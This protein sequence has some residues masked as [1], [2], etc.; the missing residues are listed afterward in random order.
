MNNV[1]CGL[2]QHSKKEMYALKNCLDKFDF[3]NLISEEFETHLYYF[4]F[5]PVVWCILRYFRTAGT[6]V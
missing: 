6:I 5:G 2:L 1:K 4:R 3:I